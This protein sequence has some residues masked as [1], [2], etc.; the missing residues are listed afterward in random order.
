MGDKSRR[1]LARAGTDPS[2]RAGGSGDKDFAQGGSAKAG[3]VGGGGVRKK[4]NRHWC[5]R[6][7]TNEEEVLTSQDQR[8]V[9]E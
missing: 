5:G 9:I 4:K 1:A 8:L 7:V 3:S 6:G 2:G